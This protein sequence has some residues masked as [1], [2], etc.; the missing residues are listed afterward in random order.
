MSSGTGKTVCCCIISK[1]PRLKFIFLSLVSGIGKDGNS[2]VFQNFLC[3]PR[4]FVS[5][6]HR[7][8]LNFGKTVRYLV[9]YC[10][11]CS[12]IAYI[13]SGYLN[14]QHKAV[15]ITGSMC[16]VRKLPLMC[17]FY[18]HSAV[19][20]GFGHRFLNRS[21]SGTSFIFV[22]IV[23]VDFLTQLFSFLGYLFAKLFLVHLRGFGDLFLLQLLFIRGCFNMCSVDKNHAWVYH[24]V[25]QCFVQ[26]MCK[27]F[28]TQLRGKAFAKGITYR[29]E[30]RDLVQ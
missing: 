4:C 3:N 9:V 14:T 15:L 26:N 19:R 30:M 16:F 24:P 20:V 12:T 29:C 1:I 13:S 6:I 2:A 10:V 5:G 25:V 7:Y 21:S 11:P 18:K 8:K 22:I 17:P 23:I 28:F 27:N